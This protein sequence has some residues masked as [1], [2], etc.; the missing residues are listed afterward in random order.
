MEGAGARLG[1]SLAVRRALR[2]DSLPLDLASLIAETHRGSQLPLSLPIF[3]SAERM[4]RKCQLGST[5]HSGWY[6]AEAPRVPFAFGDLSLEPGV[7][8]RK[9]LG[10]ACRQGLLQ[11]G[12]LDH[13]LHSRRNLPLLPACS[14]VRCYHHSPFGTSVPKF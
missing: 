6:Q 13:D 7:S 9:F 12:A 5:R 1:L 14:Q 10:V 8:P 4:R 3:G 11:G 2:L